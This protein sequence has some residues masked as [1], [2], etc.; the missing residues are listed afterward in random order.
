MLLSCGLGSSATVTASGPAAL[1]LGSAQSALSRSC[2]LSRARLSKEEDEKCLEDSSFES[3]R[4][5]LPA[6][7]IE[8]I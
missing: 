2:A 5:R 4:R 7:G 3:I 8:D 6:M 1:D